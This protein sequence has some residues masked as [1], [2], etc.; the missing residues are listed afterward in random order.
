M[1]VVVVVVCVCVCAC[2]CVRACACTRVCVCVHVCVCAHARVCVNCAHG[3]CVPLCVIYSFLWD[4]HVH[5]ISIFKAAEANISGYS[6][7]LLHAPYMI[8]FS[9]MHTFSVFK[10]YSL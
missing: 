7:K 3:A 10:K 9:K 4:I 8:F 6:H 2:A 5:Y 1:V